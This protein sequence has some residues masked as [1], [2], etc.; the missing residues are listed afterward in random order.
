MIHKK[1]LKNLKQF[2]D[3]FNYNILYYKNKNRQSFLFNIYI[4]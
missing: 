3:L 2:I 4:K 1:I